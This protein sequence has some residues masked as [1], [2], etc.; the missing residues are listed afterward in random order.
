M[1]HLFTM[2]SFVHYNMR[3]IIFIRKFLK[4][5]MVIIPKTWNSIL[6]YGTFRMVISGT[7]IPEFDA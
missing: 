5:K 6:E 3:F 4:L 2:D 1:I 7:F